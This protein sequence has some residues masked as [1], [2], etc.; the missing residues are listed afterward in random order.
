MAPKSTPLAEQRR[1][2]FDPFRFSLPKDVVKALQD[3]RSHQWFLLNLLVHDKGLPD[4]AKANPVLAYAV[5][6]WYADTRGASS[7]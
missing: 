7:T 2:A 1:R 4:L 5:A 6:Y 3:F